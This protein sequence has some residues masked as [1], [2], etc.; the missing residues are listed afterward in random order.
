MPQSPSPEPYA[1]LVADMIGYSQ[2]L[3][4]YPKE[5]HAAF[6]VHL[7][8][9]F[10]PSVEDHVGRVVKTTG[11]GIVA[12]FANPDQADQCAHVIQS[13]LEL[14][15]ASPVSPAPI[16][17]R[18]A[19]HF[20][21]IV[22]EQHDVFGLDVNI[23]IYL[24]QLAPEGGVCVSGAVFG[25][26]AEASQRRYRFVGQRY[27]KN[28]PTPVAVYRHDAARTQEEHQHHRLAPTPRN[29]LTPPPRLGLA[30]Y[31]TFAEN[32]LG[33]SIAA[34]AQD[35]VAHGLSH[36]KEMFSIA[37]LGVELTQNAAKQAR[38][39]E[40]L[41]NE[42]ACEYLLHGSCFV[43]PDTLTLTSQLELLARREL[44]WSG[45]LKVSLDQIEILDDL[46][47]SQIIAP[48]VLHLERSEA[49]AWD[50][51]L[52]SDDEIEFRDAMRLAERGTLETLDR[53]RH[54]LS[55]IINR[56]GEIGNVCI[57]MA[58]VERNHGILLAGERF[59]D[60]LE[61]ARTFAKKAVEVDDMNPRAHAELAM[62]EMFSKHQNSAAETYRH[63]L[64]LNPYD[65]LIRADWADCLVN[66]GR[67]HEA[68]PILEDVLAGWPRNRTWVEW[69]LCDAYWALGRPD[70]IIELLERHPDQPYV[71]RYL[72]ASY[73]K[74]GNTD[75]A[76]FHADRVRSH[77]PGFST[78]EWSAVV[79]FANSD[80]SE[81]Y[82]DYLE[83]A[84]L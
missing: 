69:G 55:Q 5:T 20:G 50:T 28:I 51:M 58:H 1:I 37:P 8:R 63:A 43:G 25:R 29:F 73:A 2:R 11:D 72:A 61:R 19:I 52:H 57:A 71:H 31:R 56:R 35:F 26:L 32:A 42:L 6:K 62:Q 38:F 59:V 21:T 83:R 12:I 80:S 84:G 7:D 75:Q 77:Q 76:R 78:K 14:Q 68:L 54:I 82:A 36:F 27:L 39:R 47:A 44:V 24:Q 48:V 53:A 66:L 23:A 34:M 67:A 3:A 45:K 17:Y 4:T 33:E 16:R 30:A 10:A 81:E 65:P 79:P 41:S 22:I 49:E 60:S 70:R 18:I 15:S 46:T 40:S 9:I 74:L 13:Q 64:R